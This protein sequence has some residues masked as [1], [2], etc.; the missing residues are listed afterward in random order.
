MKVLLDV[1]Q[2]HAISV[3]KY[4]FYFIYNIVDGSLEK[5][6]QFHHR[7]LYLLCL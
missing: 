7:T 2:N 3:E 5:F 1:S 4:I 6:I